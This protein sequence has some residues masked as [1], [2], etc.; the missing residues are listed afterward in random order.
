A[1]SFV[2]A[3]RNNQLPDAIGEEAAW[4][5]ARSYREQMAD[6]CAMN[7]V[8]VWYASIDAESLI[9]SFPC[10]PHPK[11]LPNPLST[12]KE[13]SPSE[14][15]LPKPPPAQGNRPVTREPPPTIFHWRKH[16]REKFVPMVEKAF[17]A[18]RTTLP[19]E[20]RVLV[21]R[22]AFKDIAIKVVGVG[23]VGTACFI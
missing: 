17:S 9:D 16:T 3:T 5:C 1:A 21:D 14:H 23:S 8:D 19:I 4:A 10:P 15:D 13:P 11:H 20:R 2:V 6:F 12:P 18:Y 22:F 7:T